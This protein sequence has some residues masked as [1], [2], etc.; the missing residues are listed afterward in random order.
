[1]AGG[2]KGGLGEGRLGWDRKG[3]CWAGAGKAR[4]GLGEERLVLGCG[5]KRFM[6]GWGTKS[7][8]PLSFYT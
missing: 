7:S 6:L 4:V 1:M 8:K 3:S 2:G 5:K